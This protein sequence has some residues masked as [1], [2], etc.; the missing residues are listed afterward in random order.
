MGAL[1]AHAEYTHQNQGVELIERRSDLVIPLNVSRSASA[2]PS[3][4]LSLA[5]RE[6]QAYQR[7]IDELPESATMEEYVNTPIEEFGAA[8][9]RGMGWK[10]GQALGK[11]GRQGRVD[12]VQ[13][14][15][16]PRLLGLGAKELPLE[17][18]EKDQ[19]RRQDGKRWIEKPG[20]GKYKAR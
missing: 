13:V 3:A 4:F 19:K 11:P 14:K 18:Q 16:R 5:E 15:V 12:P 1:E 6:Q 10:D 2:P 20:E 7:D 8:L 17:L 9:L